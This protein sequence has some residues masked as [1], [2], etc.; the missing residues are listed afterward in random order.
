MKD[1][2]YYLGRMLKLK[3]NREKSYLVV[4]TQPR[5]LNFWDPYLGKKAGFLFGFTKITANSQEQTAWSDEAESI[6]ECTGNPGRNEALYTGV[7]LLL[8]HS[9]NEVY[10]ISME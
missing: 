4:P 5:I 10:D 6:E 8:C 1:S 3:I 7:I 9:F 2:I